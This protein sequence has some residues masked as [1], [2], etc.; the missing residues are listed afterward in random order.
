MT[1]L[2]AGFTYTFDTLKNGILVAREVHHN[3]V[4]IEGLNYLLSVGF[5]AGVAYPNFYMGLYEGAYTP[6]PGDTAAT[7]PAAATELVAYAEA[8][9]LPLDFG[10]VAAGS[11][12]NSANR[13]EFT[14]TTN[15][16]QV[17][18]GF[19]SSSPTKGSATGIL[20]SAVQ[21]PSPKP[22]DAGA[23]LRATA[24]FSIVSL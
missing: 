21:F 3:L 14:G 2:A 18:G 4:P 7:F 1:K 19:I 23:V 5:K 15:G 20:V 13:V 6:V 11:M 17:R 8:T 12:D 24:A 9:R 22:L 10:A 16:K